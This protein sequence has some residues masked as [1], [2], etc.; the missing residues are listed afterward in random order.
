MSKYRKSGEVY[1]TS[2]S[3]VDPFCRSLQD[4][5]LQTSLILRVSDFLTIGR[6][7]EQTFLLVEVI[8]ELAPFK[9]SFFRNLS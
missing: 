4:E 3:E 7:T 1:H 6:S 5:V 8:R 2:Q 9:Q